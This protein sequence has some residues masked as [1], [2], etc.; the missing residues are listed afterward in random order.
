M[1]HDDTINVLALKCVGAR[2]SSQ[3]TSAVES[4]KYSKDPLD[5]FKFDSE[6][7]ETMKKDYDEVWGLLDMWANYMHTPESLAAGYPNKASGGMIGS[8]CKDTE[9]AVAAADE[10]RIT[11]IDA[12]IDSLPRCYQ[13]AINKYYG[14]GDYPDVWRFKRN[15]TFEDAKIVLRVKFVLKGL[16]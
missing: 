12:A 5:H 8:W 3:P 13:I 9:E 4:Y 16:L 6:K 14:L 1:K 11:R 2:L 10:E 15:A 7:G